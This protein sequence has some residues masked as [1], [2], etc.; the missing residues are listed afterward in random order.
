MITELE[1][2]SGLWL[3]F[4]FLAGAVARGNILGSGRAG[5]TIKVCA[6]ANQFF[7]GPNF[8]NDACCQTEWN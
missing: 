7:K 2:R 1:S 5:V 8:C 3:E 4:A 6:G